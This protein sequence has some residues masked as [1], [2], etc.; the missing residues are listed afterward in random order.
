MGV[1]V[2]GLVEG[3]AVVASEMLVRKAKMRDEK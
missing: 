1:G 3:A 2:S